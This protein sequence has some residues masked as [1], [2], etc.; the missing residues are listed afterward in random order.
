[1]RCDGC[2]QPFEPRRKDQRWCSAS[3]RLA[4]Y[5]RRQAEAAAARE[6]R[7]AEL[8]RLLAAARATLGAAERV[9]GAS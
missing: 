1:M 9:L 7:D 3:C 4:G 5:Q 6:A 2:G 8:R